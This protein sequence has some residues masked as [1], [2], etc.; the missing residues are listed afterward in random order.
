[1]TPLLYAQT[2]TPTPTPVPGDMLNEDF[3]DGVANLWTNWHNLWGVVDGQYRR[4]DLST[5]VPTSVS[6]YGDPDSVFWTD[7]LFESDFRILSS[8]ANVNEIAFFFHIQDA[9]NFYKLAFYCVNGGCRERV[10]LIAV[11]DGAVVDL[12]PETDWLLDPGALHRVAMRAV[13]ERIEVF[14]DGLPLYTGEGAGIPRGTI[15]LDAVHVDV[16]FDKVVVTSQHPVSRPPQPVIMDVFPLEGS[17]YEELTLH[18]DHFGSYTDGCAV[19]VGSQVADVVAWATT[20]IRVRATEVRDGRVRVVAANQA[21]PPD[22]SFRFRAL[23]PLLF[24]MEPPEGVT[25]REVVLYGNRL[26]WK[27][28]SESTVEVEGVPVEVLDWTEGAVKIRVPDVV[29]PNVRIK[30]RTVGGQSTLFRPVR[31]PHQLTCEVG[32]TSVAIGEPL[33]IEGFLRTGG[34]TPIRAWTIVGN[35]V[36]PTG[37]THDVLAGITS[38]EGRY[39]IV[40]DSNSPEYPLSHAGDW[41]VEMF[42]LARTWGSIVEASAVCSPI[43]VHPASCALTLDAS[44]ST[45]VQVG[46]TVQIFSVM[47]PEPNTLATRRLVSGRPLRIV[48]RK[49]SGTT[50]ELPATVHGDG[51]WS[52]GIEM[53]E[54]GV[55]RFVAHFDGDASFGATTSDELEIRV[56]ST[57]G[58][59]ILVTGTT[60]DGEGLA[61]HTRTTDYVWQ[62]LVG[63]DFQPEHIRYIRSPMLAPDGAESVPTYK[64]NVAESITDWAAD[65]MIYAPAPLFVIFVN[66]GDVVDGTGRFH[67]WNNGS[68]GGAENLIT[69]RELDEWLDVLETKLAESDQPLA[70]E[71]PIV[72]VYGACHSGSFLPTLSE[73]DK[74]RVLIAS[75]GA[76]EV[77]Y[78]GPNDDPGGATPRDG[79]YFVTRLF[80]HAGEADPDGRIPSLREAFV[81]ASED[82]AVFT[83]NLASG[84]NGRGQDR[85]ADGAGQHPQLDDNGDGRAEWPPLAADGLLADRYTVGR[86]PA[87]PLNTLRIADHIEDVYATDEPVLLWMVPSREITPSQCWI[88]IATPDSALPPPSLG[89]S[90]QRDRGLVRLAPTYLVSGLGAG[91]ISFDGV[92]G[93]RAP[94]EYVIHYYLKDEEGRTVSSETSRVFRNYAGNQPP[95][96][97]SIV[98]P[99]SETEVSTRPVVEWTAAVDPE[100]EAVAYSVEVSPFP[101]FDEEAPVWRSPWAA[102]TVRALGPQAGLLDNHNYVGR[103]V[104]RD[105]YGATRASGFVGFHAN[106]TNKVPGALV[107]VVRDGATGARIGDASV[108][109][110]PAEPVHANPQGGYYLVLTLAVGAEY[111]V[112][113]SREG[114]VSPGARRILVESTEALELEFFL[115]RRGDVDEDGRLGPR[116]I[117]LFARN[118]GAQPMPAVDLN[119]D[120]ECDEKDLLQAIGERKAA[121]HR[122]VK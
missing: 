89:E 64:Q 57:A 74:R 106:N 81:R 47:T 101:I 80:H 31:L 8:T 39:H 98:R 38:T 95:G 90:Y 4:L 60:S 102:E 26:G 40:L 11:V 48:A 6:L 87:E 15:G 37:E 73:P 55:W 14:I 112:S 105:P 44:P 97:F 50:V 56:A 77:S 54:I 27:K 12:L 108:S 114:F 62:R 52:P 17:Y 91:W 2:P 35:V 96:P 43:Q 71:Q 42:M 79:E 21:S 111:E 86:A 53:D 83:R 41:S 69:P 67:V 118:W 33:E 113:V 88:E 29:G 10:T 94:G 104:A 51:A 78:R 19:W 58:Y 20:E 3:E 63:L 119:K 84:L 23:A 59:A 45:F 76:Y 28:G 115:Y 122:R 65:M 85:Y 103:V 30:V 109:L 72:F 68:P 16:G 22:D 1:M 120:G 75:A 107:V 25:G 24:S 49:P 66:H 92:D 110:S 9:S 82:V 18:G 13:E 121:F 32:Q 100:G 70:A 117:F 93:F 46:E 7:Y 61:E 116:D 99:A 5:V 34:G 36:S